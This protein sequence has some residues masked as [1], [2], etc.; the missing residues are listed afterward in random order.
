MKKLLLL[1][2]SATVLISCEGDQGP[3][4][5]PGRDGLALLP[6][7]FEQT[8]NFSAPDYEN[9]IFYDDFVNIN[10]VGV[11]DMTLVYIL[12]DQTTDNQGNPLDVWRLL[13]QSLYSD[14]G[15]Y[16]YN[17][18]ATNLDVRVFLDGPASTDFNLLGPADLENQT[19]RVVILPVDFLNNPN[20]DVSDYNSVMQVTGLDDSDF[21]KV[22]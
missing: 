14:F 6:L 12:F 9:F 18:D 11:N 2:L 1:L 8:L 20:L 3:P 19:F 15:E 7:S 5:P 21:T 22:E 17:Y 13:P 16:Q 4:G 10:E